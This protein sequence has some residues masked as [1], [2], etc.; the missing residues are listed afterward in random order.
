[1]RRP[2]R[3]FFSFDARLHEELRSI[4]RQYQSVRTHQRGVIVWCSAGGATLVLLLARF[5]WDGFAPWM[6]PALVAVFAT[7]TALSLWKLWRDRLDIIA[8]AREIE[9]EHPELQEALRTAAEQSPGSGGKLHFLQRRLLR[10]ALD[11]AA[12]AVWHQTPRTQAR[13]L[14]PAHAIAIGAAIGLG[15]MA[16]R[17]RTPF[18]FAWP[19]Q[20]VG[21]AIAHGSGIEVTPGDVEVE[22]GA[23]VVVAARFPGKLPASANLVWQNADGQ[24][25]RESMA[26]SLS[27]PVYA[28]TLA[29]V[30]SDTVY[31]IE[32]PDGRTDEFA[33]TVFELPHL[34]RADASLDYPDYTGYTDRTITDTRRISAVEGTQLDYVFH[35]SRA[36]ATAALQDEHGNVLPLAPRNADRTTFGTTFTLA[37]SARYKLQLFD[38]ENRADPAP[39]DI[40]IEVT[41]NKRPDLK[42]D[43]PRGDQRVTPLQEIH[44]QAKVSDDFG[45]LDFGLATAVG[46]GEPDYRS[47]ADATSSAPKLEADVSYLLAL[48]DAG[49]EVD[50]LVTW[51]AWADDFA[52]DGQIR[53]TTSDLFFAEVRPFD[54]IFREDVSGG[55]G[56]EGGGG[57]AAD[58][59]QIQRQLSIAIWNLQQSSLV[60]PTYTADV[61]TLRDSQNTARA[62]LEEM[63]ARLEE[64]RLRGAASLA[65][66]SMKIAAE[67]LDDAAESASLDPLADAW[68]A[69]QSAYRA[70]LKLQPRETN[71]A[72]NSGQGGS[73]QRNQGQINQLRLRNEANNYETASE[74]E[75]PTSP[76]DREQ[77]NLLSKLKDL[78]RRQQD[79]NERLQELQTALAAANDE[80]ER[81][82]IRRELK[83]LEEE[84]RRMLA[85]LDE[86]RQNLD[87][88]NSGEQRE[89]ARQQLDQSRED[90]QEVSERLSSGEVSSALASGTRAQES[91]ESTREQLREESSSVFSEQLREL[92][93]QARE[94]SAQQD[95]L[96]QQWRDE[97]EKP[98]SLDDSASREALA[99]SLDAQRERHGNLL[100]DMRQI[101]EDSEGTEP[102]LHRQLYDLMRE[103]GSDGPSRELETSA[104]LLRRGFLD[105]ARRQQAGVGEAFEQLQ[106]SIERAAESVL[107]SEATEMK[108]ARNELEQLARELGGE[109]PTPSEPGTTQSPT[110]IPGRES[111]EELTGTGTEPGTEPGTRPAP[112]EGEGEL[113]VA[114]GEGPSSDE[115][116]GTT[117]S[118]EPGE[119]ARVATATS[120][121]GDQSGASPG[122]GVGDQPSSTPS[123]PEP[124][125]SFEETL[126]R[127]LPGGTRR[128]G[129]GRREGN[130]PITGRDF[131]DWADRLRTVESLLESEDLRQRLAEARGEAE[132]LRREWKRNG[133]APQWDLVDTGV[134]SPLNEVRRW[135][136]QEIARREDPTSLQPID[137]DPVP[138]KYAEAVRQYYEALGGAN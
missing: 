47:F 138:D 106:A 75:S 61:A 24:T 119:G 124:V 125:E 108:F 67:E 59:L 103:Q 93:R 80:A 132:D 99:E 8:T 19:F 72:Q 37:E 46:N 102:T 18:D 107:G 60:G 30:E 17:Y 86:A 5:Q 131:G 74:A 14:G 1:M 33:L 94:L 127:L 110:S 92:R 90:M 78:S 133:A 34:V 15:V 88:M 91:L 32:Y 137:R 97:Q 55:G 62:Q 79:L 120:T 36:L 31:A 3:L 66:Q 89:Q 117:P 39:A 38:H 82:R 23:T 109:R 71:V 13:W 70:L 44:F 81:D 98:P 114:G 7:A 11:H 40:R 12:T 105:Q 52:P 57:P 16:L 77:L 9:R 45:L 121:T 126:A 123:G 21:A 65:G 50:E 2:L 41:Q 43:F 101:T 4:A 25:G 111:G 58:L 136:D 53:R 10:H 6:G 54:E 28:F 85:D 84:Q 87:R 122:N 26:P 95:Q 129:E 63:R 76:E 115:Q 113:R 100:R 68:T 116:N 64:P 96:A 130:G 20:S 69:S 49:V 42:I 134:V 56:G 48:E 118:N 73:G 51:F 104:E 128:G 27:D 29:N 112:G 22:T 83:R 135:L 35:V